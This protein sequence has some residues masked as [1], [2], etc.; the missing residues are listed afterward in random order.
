MMVTTSAGAEALELGDLN[1]ELNYL[2]GPFSW[3]FA[4][5]LFYVLEDLAL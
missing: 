4:F 1:Q 5:L 3:I 2:L